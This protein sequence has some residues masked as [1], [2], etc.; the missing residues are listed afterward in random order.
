MIF[1]ARFPAT[2]E[3]KNL[4]WYKVDY[5]T[6]YMYKKGIKYLQDKGRNIIGIVCDGRRGLLGGFGDIPTQMCLTHQKGIIRRYLTNK[7]RIEANRELKE[8][9]DDIGK[10]SEEILYIRL[11]DWHRRNKEW[12]FE[13]NEN[14]NYRHERTIK[15]YKSIK[16]NLPVRLYSVVKNNVYTKYYLFDNKLCNEYT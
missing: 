13:K 2:G 6:N 1:R 8:I 7:P 11:K 10:W 16:K 5:E 4:L 14:N 15:A 12:L 9:A 3:G